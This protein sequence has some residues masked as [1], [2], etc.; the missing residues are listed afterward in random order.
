MRNKPPFQFLS[1]LDSRETHH[2]RRIEQFLALLGAVLR[3]V[4]HRIEAALYNRTRGCRR[5]DRWNGHHLYSENTERMRDE[6]ST[7]LS[8]F[9]DHAAMRRRIVTLLHVCRCLL[10]N[11]SLLMRSSSVRRLEYAACFSL[12]QVSNSAFCSGVICCPVGSRN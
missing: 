4:R 6:M 8:A 12:S 9:S 5:R 10:L 11:C 2:G 7:C 1:P 3:L